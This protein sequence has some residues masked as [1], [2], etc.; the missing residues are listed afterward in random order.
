MG[1]RDASVRLNRQQASSSGEHSTELALTRTSL[2]LDRTLMAWVRTSTSLISF[3]FTIY[4][5]FQYLRE[6]RVPRETL[7]GPRGIALVLIALGVGAL[8]VATAEYRRHRRT[9]RQEFPGYQLPGG[10]LPAGVAGTLAGL[11]VL[12][13][14]LVSL[15]L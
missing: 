7:L 15:R 8:A 11:G 13:F 9:L 12:A 5:F 1:T 6:E 4:K 3:G 14:V 10:A 2:A